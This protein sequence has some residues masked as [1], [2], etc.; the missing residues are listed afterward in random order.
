MLHTDSIPMTR[1]NLAFERKLLSQIGLKALRQREINALKLSF[2]AAAALDKDGHYAIS[3]VASDPAWPFVVRSVKAT[4]YFDP[5]YPCTQ[6]HVSFPDS[7]TIPKPVIKV[8]N[9]EAS[10]WIENRFN[11]YQK[12]GFVE[13]VFRTFIKWFDRHME[14]FFLRGLREELLLRK[15]ENDDVCNPAAA[16]HTSLRLSSEEKED[17]ISVSVDD[18][19]PTGNASNTVGQEHRSINDV[20]LSFT[21]LNLGENVG[22]IEL[23]SLHSTFQCSRCHGLHVLRL[24]P[25][26][27]VDV[28]C[29]KCKQIMSA[30][31]LP[32]IAHQN[33]FI[34]G[35]LQLANASVFDLSLSD[36]KISIN[37]L[38]CNAM[39]PI[40][41]ITAENV[42]MRWCY[43]CFAK[44]RI[45]VGGIRSSVDRVTY[46]KTPAIAA[47]SLRRKRSPDRV[48]LKP[49]TALPLQGTCKHYRKSYR[50]FRFPCCNHL[51]P[52]DECHAENEDHESKMANRII[53]GFCS[54]EQRCVGEKTCIYCKHSVVKTT[55][56]HW[57]GGKG[58]REKSA[59]STKDR[60]K[61]RGLAKAQLK[62]R[63]TR[64]VR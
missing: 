35:H 47:S 19:T 5:D 7:S 54:N 16:D 45:T 27:N 29:A 56:G 17:D 21:N 33:S 53:C 63:T 50:W 24:A 31:L 32:E 43:H 4:V 25:M 46:S 49:G 62:K 3:I 1:N 30:K 26:K 52:C 60:A 57:E 61:Y 38:N 22:T 34:F 55:T 10:K 14:T 20:I 42:E 48:S 44:I 23:T 39:Q 41:G 28:I 12:A 11:D 6:C 36:S 59:M 15:Q 2:P 9:E 8:L 18:D 64:S 58:C 37:C 40:S 51:Y 13:L